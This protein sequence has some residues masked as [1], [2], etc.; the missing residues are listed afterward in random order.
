MTRINLVTTNDERAKFVQKELTSFGIEIN[1][2]PLKLDEIQADTA[3]E[4][5][6]QKALTA[7]KELNE[8]CICEDTEFRVKTLNGFPGPYFKFIQKTITIEKL[9]ILMQGANDREATFKS[10]L[11]YAEPNGFHKSF[12]TTLNCEILQTPKGINEKRWDS[13][14][15]IKETGKSIAE[16]TNDEKIKL[17]N[18]GY[19]KF[20]KWFLAK[21]NSSMNPEKHNTE[22]YDFS[23]ATHY[24]V[25]VFVIHEEKLL[26]L[27]QDRSSFWLL[28]G[29]H[30][31]DNEL[32]HEAAIRELKEET[33][34]DI[35]LLQKPDE[36][37][38]TKIATPLP[39]PITMQLLPCRNKRDVSIYYTA[40]V[41]S[42]ELKTDFESKEAKWFTKKEIQADPLIGPNTKYYAKK[43]LKKSTK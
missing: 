21:E 8:A 15:K 13:I 18:K 39:K 6:I 22:T 4:I 42:G 36:K 17:W 23:R 11:V 19:K 2:K 33:G 35:E 26:L 20:G 7:A 3:E 31:E 16:Y 24:T 40:K 5:A 12:E 32:P 34:L 43:I 1:R 25:A 29:G 10:I 30:I 28:P 27:K 37:A 41:I 9:L 38:R 14:I